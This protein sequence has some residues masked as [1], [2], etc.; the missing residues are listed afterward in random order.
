MFTVWWVYWKL[1]VDLQGLEKQIDEK[2]IREEEEK[3]I[4][5]AYRQKQTTDAEIAKRLER[6]IEEV[7]TFI[8]IELPGPENKQQIQKY[9]YII[10]ERAPILNL[11]N[12]N[13]ITHC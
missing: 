6:H 13:Q 1:Q 10:L 11:F 12:I 8:A 3:K 7:P 9:I 4:D 2:K 5:E